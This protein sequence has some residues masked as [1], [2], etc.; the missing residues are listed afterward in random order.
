MKKEC[1]PQEHTTCS[2]P[3]KSDEQNTDVFS[4]YKIPSRSHHNGFVRTG[5]LGHT[6]VRLGHVILGHC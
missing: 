5:A 4:Y 6:Y 3:N 1:R 2:S